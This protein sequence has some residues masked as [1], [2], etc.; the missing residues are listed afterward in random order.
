LIK[1]AAFTALGMAAAFASVAAASKYWLKVERYA[2]KTPGLPGRGF[3]LLQISDLHAYSLKKPRPNIW[4]AVAR[5][6]FDAVMLT[7]DMIR[8]DYEQLMP[9]LPYIRALCARAPVFFAEGN[10][11]LRHGYGTKELLEQC[12]VVTLYNERV[13]AVLNGVAVDIIGLRDYGWFKAESRRNPRCKSAVRDGLFSDT[14]RRFT[15]VLCHQPQLFEAFAGSGADLTLA[16]HTHGG[17]VR[18]PFLPV[19][20]APGQ[21]LLPRYGT[22]FYRA[23]KS[24]M[25]VSGG[26]GATVF[27]LRLF[28]RPSVAV[29][30]IGV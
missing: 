24:L 14:A 18:L 3:K 17:Q 30:E 10:H 28:N 12:G 22:G 2:L 4:R 1:A 8:A 29:F 5:L 19:L 21:G 13:Q 6:D 11:E 9:H 23:G 26:V 27:S 15:I 16:G 20:Y 7:G 25:Y